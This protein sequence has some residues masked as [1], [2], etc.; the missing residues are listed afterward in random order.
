MSKA[1]LQRNIACQ[2]IE[3]SRVRVQRSL[4]T[5][6]PRLFPISNFTALTPCLQVKMASTKVSIQPEDEVGHFRAIS[7]CASH[8][9]AP[10]LTITPAFSRTPRPNY[11]DALFSQTLK[12]PDTVSAFVCFYPRPADERKT[13]PELKAL[14]TLG[15]L[16][17]GYGGISHGG[18][19]ASLLDETLSFIHPGSRWRAYK[20]GVAPVVTAYLTTKYLRP[21]KLPGTYL[22][23]VWLAKR[24]GR[25]IFVEGVMEDE[26]GEKVARADALFVETR[27]KL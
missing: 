9:Q 5:S 11:E 27:E 6:L 13:L 16:V 25:K 21:V 22:I 14:V 10:D 3:G 4:R 26:H 20:D 23:T 1:S 12:T 15:N 19:V 2:L 18:V 24:D 8:L 17:A 7:W